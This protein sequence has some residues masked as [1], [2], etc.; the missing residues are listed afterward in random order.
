MLSGI[1]LQPCFPLFLFVCR[2]SISD[3]ITG[4]V[5]LWPC[6]LLSPVLSPV[7]SVMVSV[8]SL[9]SFCFPWFV[10]G[11]GLASGCLP[12]ARCPVSADVRLLR[13]WA[14]WP[15]RLRDCNRYRSAEHL[16]T[17]YGLH[18][19]FILLSAVRSWS[20]WR[21][22]SQFFNPGMIGWRR[23]HF[24]GCFKPRSSDG[25]LW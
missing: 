11:H 13:P 16:K 17:R 23:R 5:R 22:H 10:S 12:F 7:I 6:F 9:V 20:E 24:L 21:F 15:N 19:I 18:A 8:S 3:R 25:C 4:G 1:R 14:R 2:Q